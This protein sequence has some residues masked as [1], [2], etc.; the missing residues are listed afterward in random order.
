L[1]SRPGSSVGASRPVV[2]VLFRMVPFSSAMGPL[3]LL[4]V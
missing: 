3:P 2:A 4:L 1:T